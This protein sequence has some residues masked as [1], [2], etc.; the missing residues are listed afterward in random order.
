[1]LDLQDVKISSLYGCAVQGPVGLGHFSGAMSKY[2][3]ERVVLMKK[4]LR[5]SAQQAASGCATGSCTSDVLDRLRL[6]AKD[7][8]IE[9]FVSL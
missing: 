3:K 6:S 2:Q 9:E 5:F 1:L 7:L 8:G 4:T